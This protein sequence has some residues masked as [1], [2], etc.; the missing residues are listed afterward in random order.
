MFL[1]MVFETV[2]GAVVT[3]VTNMVARLKK[4]E[5]TFTAVQSGSGDPSPSNIRPISGRTGLTI[6]RTGKNLLDKSQGS[7]ISSRYMYWGTDGYN[8][9]TPN[10]TLK[11]E[12]GTYTLSLSGD[13][14]TVAESMSVCDSTA[15]RVKIVYNN[16]ICK[17]TLTESGAVGI[18]IVISSGNFIS[19]ENYNIQLELGSTATEYEPY[20]G[21][22]YAVDW[23]D[24]AGTVYGGYLD[25][26]TGLL[27]I[28]RKLITISNAPYM[29]ASYIKA[30][31][32]N[33]YALDNT[34]YPQR[35]QN[36]Q[37][38]DLA[39]DALNFVKKSVWGTQ[40]YANCFCI[41]V[42]QIHINLAN[43][44]IGV[45]DYTSETVTTAKAK[46]N[47]YLADH[48]ISFVIPV[49]ETTVQLTPTEIKALKG[50]NTI[51]ADGDSIE[52]TYQ[53]HL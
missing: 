44:I 20:E 33:A 47:A 32:C 27:T 16:K 39:S 17:F 37:P 35:G 15:T 7:V 34:I 30:D 46:I 42:N 8:N 14:S 1:R 12:A 6:K 24:E 3:F 41:N 13:A 45:T 31:A 36:A 51:W 19:W 29:S 50:N 9:A 38:D 53:K 10:G 2:S 22:S 23:Q 18:F 26:T 48:P 28:N 11:L 49:R 52:V 40:G 25:A 5:V 21:E 43:D 4:C